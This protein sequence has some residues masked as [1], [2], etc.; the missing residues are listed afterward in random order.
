[1]LSLLAVARGNDGLGALPEGCDGVGR[2]INEERN[3]RAVVE[4]EGDRPVVVALV[5]LAWRAGAVGVVVDPIRPNNFRPVG[6]VPSF[7]LTIA[8]AELRALKS[9]ILSDGLLNGGVAALEGSGVLA[10]AEVGPA[11]DEGL[12]VVLAVP[13][14]FDDAFVPGARHEALEDEVDRGF[15]GLAIDVRM[16]CVDLSVVVVCLV[17]RFPDEQLVLV[18]L[19][20]ALAEFT[21]DGDL[22]GHWSAGKCVRAAGAGEHGRGQHNARAKGTEQRQR[23][24]TPKE[25]NMQAEIIMERPC[26]QSLRLAGIRR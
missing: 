3:C 19:E 11:R 6:V 21:V 1:M 23:G 18:I 15:A 5:R 10:L 20:D 22:V 24:R 13:E 4:D 25:S 14:D 9:N 8:E 12:V 2:V 7:L 16:D 26:A 17:E